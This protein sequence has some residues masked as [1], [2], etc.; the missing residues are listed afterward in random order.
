MDAPTQN[1]AR[2]Q[3]PTRETKLLIAVWVL[4]VAVGVAILVLVGTLVVNQLFSGSLAT[5]Y[6]QPLHVVESQLQLDDVGQ[7]VI[8]R[9]F[10]NS[11]LRPLG[12]GGAN[13]QAN[14]KITGAGVDDKLAA[15]LRSLGYVY[16]GTQIEQPSLRETSNWRLGDCLITV[17]TRSYG[18][19]LYL[20]VSSF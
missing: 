17:T 4:S 12:L 19:D 3:R 10:D 15:R 7:T 6:K 2:V 16:G 14:I 9:E 8:E 1:P 18:V 20:L 13:M 5:A 11:G